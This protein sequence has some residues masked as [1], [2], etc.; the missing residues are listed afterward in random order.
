MSL[1]LLRRK[2]FILKML[3]YQILFYCMPRSTK[4]AQVDLFFWRLTRL[5]AV[6]KNQ[7]FGMPFW[8]ETVISWF[9]LSQDFRFISIAL[10]SLLKKVLCLSISTIMRYSVKLQMCFWIIFLKN[11]HLS[12]WIALCSPIYWFIWKIILVVKHFLLWNF[13]IIFV[14]IISAMS[15][16]AFWQSICTYEIA[17]F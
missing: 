13:V 9:R 4:L 6:Q 11:I 12:S 10:R 14:K 5:K 16:K 7:L 2:I 17:S 1:L 8:S 15:N 3:N